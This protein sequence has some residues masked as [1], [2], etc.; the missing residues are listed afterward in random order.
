MN[1][2]KGSD[3]SDHIESELTY[4]IDQGFQSEYPIKVRHVE[5]ISDSVISFPSGRLDLIPGDYTIIDK[6]SYNDVT[7][8]EPSFTLRDDQQKAL[9]FFS[10]GASGLLNCKP[11]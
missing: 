11:G 8:P 5:R 2:P 7:I 6:R 1:C 3:L 4:E 9:D 10:D